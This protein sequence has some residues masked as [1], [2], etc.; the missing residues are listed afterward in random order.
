MP[1]LVLNVDG[2]PFVF[3]DKHTIFGI[4]LFVVLHRWNLGE[5]KRFDQVALILFVIFMTL[6]YKQLRSIFVLFGFCI[7][8]TDC[9]FFSDLLESVEMLIDTVVKSWWDLLVVS[10]AFFKGSLLRVS[11]SLDNLDFTVS[12]ALDGTIADAID[13]SH[14][15]SLIE[16][17][18]LQTV[19]AFELWTLLKHG[20][21]ARF[22]CIVLW[23]AYLCLELM[24]LVSCQLF[25]RSLAAHIILAL[26][27]FILI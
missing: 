12:T 4:A 15:E 3:E 11:E 14:R 25:L 23:V 1:K 9:V 17:L 27:V 6:V 24:D 21:E 8:A 22:A 20:T 18:Y 26:A 19:E 5:L 13:S 2:A 10:K 7:V 16:G